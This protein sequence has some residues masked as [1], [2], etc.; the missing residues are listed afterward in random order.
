MLQRWR[1]LVELL[2][3]QVLSGDSQHLAFAN[4]LHRVDS[5]ARSRF[6]PRA[7]HGR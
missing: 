3:V 5:G 6:G 7:L 1:F 2:P 4:H